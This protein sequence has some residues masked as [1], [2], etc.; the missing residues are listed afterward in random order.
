MV[1]SCCEPRGIFMPDGAQFYIQDALVM[2]ECTALFSLFGGVWTDI[3]PVQCLES[4]RI[5]CK[6]VF[7]SLTRVASYSWTFFFA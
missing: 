4:P 6:P 2:F 5:S 7:M 1:A 3:Q